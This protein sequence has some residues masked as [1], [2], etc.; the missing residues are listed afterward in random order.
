MLD[1]KIY[2]N[3]AQ[4]KI[5]KITMKQILSLLIFLLFGVLYSFS[6]DSIQTFEVNGVSFS[7]IYVEGGT[8]SMGATEEQGPNVEKDE[9]PVHQVTVSS[10]Y[11]GQTEVTQELWLAVTG[12]DIS[13]F[14]G[15]KRPVECVDQWRIKDFIKLLNKMT[16]LQFRLPTEAEWEYAARGGNKSKGYRFSGSNI[17]DEVAWYYDNSFDQTHDVATKAPNELGIYDMTGNVTEFCQDGYDEKYYKKS[18]SVDPKGPNPD[19]YPSQ[20]IRGGT[21]YKDEA[22]SHLSNRARGSDKFS[23]LGASQ[24]FRI[25]LDVSK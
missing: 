15:A 11:I 5:E 14:K 13:H 1:F 4:F 16:G 8:F 6:Q 22:G 3:F 17:I 20:V 21:Y 7:L 23:H 25:A 10:F 12:T 19:K 18:P 24:G 2:N 9:K